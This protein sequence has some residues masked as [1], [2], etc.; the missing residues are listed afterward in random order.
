MSWPVRTSVA[1]A[2]VASL[3]AAVALLVLPTRTSSNH[4]AILDIV[5]RVQGSRLV[6][7]DTT[8]Q[9]KAPVQWATGTI[10]QEKLPK[11]WEFAAGSNLSGRRE[12]GIGYRLLPFPTV[13][14]ATHHLSRVF[15]VNGQLTLQQGAWSVG[16]SAGQ[17]LTYAIHDHLASFEYAS[18]TCELNV[19][20]MYNVIGQPYSGCPAQPKHPLGVEEPQERDV[21][22]HALII[23]NAASWV[24][25]L[26]LGYGISA[27]Q[28]KSGLPSYYFWPKSTNLDY[29]LCGHA[30]IFERAT[31][32]LALHGASTGW[33]VTFTF[34]QRGRLLEAGGPAFRVRVGATYPLLS[35]RD[36][37]A[38]LDRT[39]PTQGAGLEGPFPLIRCSEKH[40]HAVNCPVKR[41]QIRILPPWPVGHATLTQVAMASTIYVLKD[42][43]L[44]GLPTYIF[45]GAMYGTKKDALLQGQ[46][47]QL[48]VVPSAVR[49]STPA[50]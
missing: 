10:L 34:D 15:G 26:G 36:A 11:T 22:T 8:G 37:V 43:S 45:T 2:A 39:H 49:F 44:I 16:S 41:C 17:Q 14:A 19:I 5:A 12:R 50:V 24:R 40:C 1:I 33:S 47:E 38:V 31:F 29:A 23:K 48:A 21:L 4:A 13:D 27:P 30:C 32:Y 25:R 35:Q 9:P 3:V 42:G 7:L 18:R 6:S 46:W 28:Y 20:D